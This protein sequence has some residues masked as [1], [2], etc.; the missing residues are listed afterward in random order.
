MIRRPPRSTRTDTLFPYTTLFRSQDLVDAG[1]AVALRRF[2]VERQVLGNRD[3][4]ILQLQVDRLVFLVI[5]IRQEDRRQLVEA[6]LAIRLGISNRLAVL[7]RL[8]TLVIGLGMRRR[9]RHQE[10]EPEIVQPPVAAAQKG[11]RK[12]VGKGKGGEE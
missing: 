1:R 4:R 7:R 12:S 2:V 6:D 3:R 10:A 9:P 11:E 8:Q 5:G